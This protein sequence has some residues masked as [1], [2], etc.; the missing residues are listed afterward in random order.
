MIQDNELEH[1]LKA[2]AIEPGRRPE[3]YRCLL[4]ADVWIL[5]GGT[6]FGST[7]PAG[8]QIDL[9]QWR[10]GDGAWIIPFFSSIAM[11]RQ[12]APLGTNAACMTGRELF[13]YTCGT[14]LVLNPNCEF[15]REFSPH[16]VEALLEHGSPVPPDCEILQESRGVALEP[17]DELPTMVES[18]RVLYATRPSVQAA[19]IVRA[20][21]ENEP[22]RPMLL[23]GIEA[24]S[25][26]VAILEDTAAVLRD[27][28]APGEF[29]D[30]MPLNPADGAIGQHIAEMTAPFYQRHA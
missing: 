6:A 16:E 22:T 19:Y 18:L 1:L 30:A 28:C 10:R 8:A 15:G 17:L 9:V 24:L 23:V 14:P 26:E 20:R 7:I 21:Y 5:L 4:E 27:V 2:A 25:S 12:G 13:L 29:V 11:T 3:F